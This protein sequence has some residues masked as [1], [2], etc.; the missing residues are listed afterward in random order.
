MLRRLRNFV[1]I[2]MVGWFLNNFDIFSFICV[3]ILFTKYHKNTDISLMKNNQLFGKQGSSTKITESKLKSKLHYNII[4]C[5][6]IL[7]FEFA[8]YIA[9]NFRVTRLSIM[10]I[11]LWYYLH[12]KLKSFCFIRI[13]PKW[14]KNLI[15]F[16]SFKT[17][18]FAKKVHRGILCI[19]KVCFYLMKGLMVWFSKWWNC[20]NIILVRYYHYYLPVGK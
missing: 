5:I 13:R 4:I 12:S 11:W 6:M 14:H 10:S 18:E 8:F 15:R 17:C 1:Y 16:V 19:R 3:I 7:G 2:F 9:F 20:I